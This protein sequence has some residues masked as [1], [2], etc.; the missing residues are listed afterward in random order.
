MLEFTTH[1][2]AYTVAIEL[3]DPSAA[4]RSL[5]KLRAIAA[6]IGEPGM[7]WTVGIYDTFDATMAARLD[8]AELLVN[9]NLELGMHIGE[10]DAF[11]VYAT[12]FYA[13]GTFAGRH[14][15]LF[16]IVEELSKEA[17]TASPIRI[18]YAVICA[19]VDRADTARAIFA[20]TQAVGFSDIPKDMFWMTSV[21]GCAVL[22][23]ELQ[24]A[25]AAAAIFPV[26]EPF[27]AEVAFNG[28]TSQGPIAAY[29]GKL[30]SLLGQH[31]LADGY[32]RAALDT[33]IAFGWEYH[34]ATTLIAL[35]QS[36]VRR[37][38]GLDSEAHAWLEQA[39]GICSA[40]GLR[41]WAAQIELLRS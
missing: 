41:S 8:D 18:A 2:A 23:V 15:E 19:A 27:A 34:R 14:A 1:I 26:L 6:E 24:D 37:S 40:R 9:A 29:L 16:P 20:E 11:T 5:S 35:A 31:D 30:A 21:V 10:P 25:D 33:A 17:P 7:R 36:R 4:A 3:A 13:L 38:G 22:A 12:Q 32:L 39:G 28:G